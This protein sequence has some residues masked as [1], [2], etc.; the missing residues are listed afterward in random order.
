M[1]A[2]YSVDEVLEEAANCPHLTKKRAMLEQL[3]KRI[4]ADERAV[5]FAWCRAEDLPRMD[6]I[7]KSRT[8]A[9]ALGLYVTAERDEDHTTAVYVDRPPDTIDGPASKR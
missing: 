1:N 8:A 9:G 5:P 2:E 7:R 4:E 3:A 6:K